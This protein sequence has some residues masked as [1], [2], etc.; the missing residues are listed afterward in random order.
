M[1]VIGIVGKRK[2]ISEGIWDGIVRGYEMVKGMKCLM[3]IIY[4]Y[5][6]LLIY[7]YK[8]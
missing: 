7:G 1:D 8:N 2:E 5:D 6:M 4:N 3:Y